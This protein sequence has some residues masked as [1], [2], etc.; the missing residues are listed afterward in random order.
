MIAS[1]L[2]PDDVETHENLGLLFLRRGQ[3]DEALMQ[4]EETLRLRPDA[5]P[6]TPSASHN[7]RK[8][9]PGQPP[10][11]MKPPSN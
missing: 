1:W 10:F 2:K 4:F 9:R 8:G 7:S 11:I 3:P 6:I 5:D